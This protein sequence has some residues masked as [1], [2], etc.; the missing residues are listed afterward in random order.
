MRGRFNPVEGWVKVGGV[1]NQY[2]QNKLKPGRIIIVSSGTSW[3]AGMIGEYLFEDL[4]RI[5]VEVE[6]SSEFRYR[7]PILS[8]E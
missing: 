2:R 1:N 4:A 6:Y 5:P 7:N 8:I 3:H